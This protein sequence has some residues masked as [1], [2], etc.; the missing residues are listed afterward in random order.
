MILFKVSAAKILVFVFSLFPIK[1]NKLLFM[2]YDGGQYSC[3]PKY[4]TEHILANRKEEFDIVWIL[5]KKGSYP[6]KTAKAMS[7]KAFFHFATARVLISNQRLPVFFTKRKEQFYLQTWHS[8]LRLKQI[9]KDTQATLKKE[10]I[11]RAV[12]DS[13]MCNLLLSGCQKSTEIMKNAFWY[14]GEIFE[15]GTPRNDILLSADKKKAEE[16][17]GKYQLTQKRIALYA[18]TFRSGRKNVYPGS[19]FKKTLNENFTGDW[20]VVV[21]LH[22]HVKEE[23]IEAEGLFLKDVEDTQELLIAADILI[24]DYSSLMFD[25]A[26]TGKPIILFAPDLMEY[27]KRERKLYFQ[28]EELPFP[29]AQTEEDLNRILKNWDD[30]NYRE[31]LSSFIEEIGTFEDGQAS[32]AVTNKLSEICMQKEMKYVETL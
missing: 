10:Y 14:N 7:L 29:I 16:I 15:S 19:N 8:S 18:P 28:L 31:K 9:E 1:R 30:R 26:L 12:K 25:F 5:N 6:F 32:A 23:N 2:S 13:S 17:K 20:E 21:K 22:P 11:Q 4:I 3:N 24:T 27:Q